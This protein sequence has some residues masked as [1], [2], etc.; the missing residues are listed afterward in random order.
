MFDGLDLDSDC[1]GFLLVN[2]AFNSNKL[3]D[4]CE[5]FRWLSLSTNIE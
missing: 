5:M 4:D 1:V 2:K 3:V